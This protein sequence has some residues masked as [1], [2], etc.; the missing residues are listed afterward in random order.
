LI[1]ATHLDLSDRGQTDRAISI[2]VLAIF[3]AHPP[4]LPIM[5]AGHKPRNGVSL[6][7]EIDRY[8]TG[9]PSLAWTGMSTPAMVFISH[10]SDMAGFPLERTF[11]RAACD[12]VLRAGAVPIDMAYF[13]ARPERPADYCRRRVRECDIYMGIIG[14]RY[15]SKVLDQEM[16]SYTELEFDEATTAGKPRILFLLDEDTPI[17]RRLIDVDGRL[18]ETFRQRIRDSGVI[19]KSFSSPG[20]LGEG[21]LHALGELQAVQTMHGPRDTPWMV[22]APATAV[23]ER[24]EI[25]SLV[26]ESLLSTKADLFTIPT[27]LEGAGG[28]GKTTLAA[29][30]CRNS[31][32]RKRYPGGV[33]WVTIGEHVAEVALAKLINGLSET[34]AGKPPTISDP[35]LAG[36]YLGRLLDERD[37]ILMVID[38]VWRSTQLAPF[39]L[40]GKSARRLV[41]TRIRDVL[42]RGTR[43]IPVDEMKADQALQALTAQAD[44]ISAPLVDDLL[45]LTGRWPV[46]LSLVNASLV[47]HIASG[48][49]GDLAAG[50]VI[51][52]L[53]AGG[54]T[55]LDVD[56]PD[57]R[58]KAVSATVEA[59][60]SFLSDQEQERYFDLAVLPE[61]VEIPASVLALLWAAT[62]SL[63]TEASNRLTDKIARLRLVVRRWQGDAPVVRLHDTIRAYLRHRATLGGIIERNR[64]F[65]RAAH[66]ALVGTQINLSAR[67]W[68][69]L[70]SHSL[71]FWQHLTYHMREAGLDE[72][73]AAVVCDLRWVT[74]KIDIFGTA[75]PVEADLAL[76][77]TPVTASLQRAI[78]RSSAVLTPL[79]PGPALGSTVANLLPNVPELANLVTDYRATLGVP[80]LDIVWPSPDQPDPAL[81]RTLLAHTDWA[82]SCAF[83]PDGTLLA[84]T[85][86]DFS[87]RLWD[88]RT[89]TLRATL[90]GHTGPVSRCAFSPDGTLIAT[91]SFDGTACLW[92]VAT[93]LLHRTLTGHGN[94]VRG[95]SFNPD[96]RLL[97]TASDDGTIRIWS[98]VSGALQQALADHDEPVLD[99]AFSPDGTLIATASSE[100]VVR[101]WRLENGKSHQLPGGHTGPINRCVFSPDGTFLATSG[102]D[103]TVRLWVTATG[104]P[105]QILN[106]HTDQ[107]TS[108]VFSPN[109][110]LL[111]STS[112]DRTVRLWHVASGSPQR[113]LT[114]H[115]DA[116]TDCA[117]SPD[118]RLLATSSVDRSVHMWE[119]GSHRL[120]RTPRHTDWVRSCAF[121]PDGTLLA[122]TSD[123]HTTRLWHIPTGELHHT[124]NG[125]TDWVRSCAFSP[126]GTLLA[127]TSDD[128]TTRLWH[129]PTGELHHT[130]AGHQ[131]WVTS[132]AFSP[133]GRLL[134]T[135]SF[136][137]S[138]RV[139]DVATH[140]LTRLLNGHTAPVTNCEFS[141]DGSLLATT[142]FDATVRLWN[143]ATGQN[144]ILDDSAD[145]LQACA[146]SPDGTLIVAVGDD[147]IPRVW[148]TSSGRCVA[149]VRVAQP[150]YDCAWHPH[151]MM[152]CVVGRAGV[153]LFDYLDR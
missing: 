136:D 141:T 25:S 61:D 46:L 148:S 117:F 13:A 133:D 78:A 79:E 73:L 137:A 36:S 101:L 88:T 142:S 51:G 127:T 35:M 41:T 91:T 111:A 82:R 1:D 99:C 59:S 102:V 50:W 21:I 138:V 53:A 71:Y 103:Q 135:T 55:A 14:F 67:R 152:V 74:A 58:N 47:E 10:T 130:F 37:P 86:D 32:V 49:E 147:Q 114:G 134:A 149:A 17:P 140:S 92:H 23:V 11:V 45:R 3:T 52:R 121:S 143:T 19:V 31:G 90:T 44:G 40:G 93:G 60:L 112:F 16:I 145:W 107:V 131:S 96:G 146:F 70:P 26:L 6:M 77:G 69:S 94:W 72:E 8:A 54:P 66:T 150:L 80:R 89:G 144:L 100:G 151:G 22:P 126:D 27:A 87:L 34:L 68:W 129:I 42:P 76:I 104:R 5:A 39:L 125:H 153:Y 18:I 128:H 75:L 38:D 64:V 139:W 119:P 2:H 24:P 84:S 63:D 109:G 4:S 85:S 12:A 9:I 30:V 98:P 57:S 123:D 65:V 29:H 118:G 132:C 83:S 7:I 124:L 97:A 28:F 120:D 62:G 110:S 108:C 122:T 48:A 115:A 20:D 105:W 95:C 43:S 106:G 56:D 15:G 81:L 33:L 113:S 116:V